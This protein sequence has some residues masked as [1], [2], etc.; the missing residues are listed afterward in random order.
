MPPFSPPQ[1]PWIGVSLE[2][3]PFGTWGCGKRK[4]KFVWGIAVSELVGFFF[5]FPTILYTWDIVI[6]F[7]KNWYPIN[8]PWYYLG[9]IN[10]I[11]GAPFYDLS[12]VQWACDHVFI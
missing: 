12:H 11:Q 9:Y 10:Q 8:A 3:E 7:K 4:V 5:S 2:T 1:I 6:P